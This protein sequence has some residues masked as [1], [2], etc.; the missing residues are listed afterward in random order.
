LLQ[1]SIVNKELTGNEYFKR[2]YIMVDLVLREENLINRIFL[3]RGE[4][5]MLDFDLAMLYETEA[6]R[7]KASVRRNIDRFPGDFMFEL[8]KEEYNSLRTKFSSSNRG[9]I[10]YMPYAFT[11]QGVAMLSTVLKSK[12]AIEVNI[13]IMRI[14]VQ[15]RKIANIHKELFERIENLETNFE[16]LKDLVRSLL[17]QETKPK[18]KIGFIEA[19]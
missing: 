1:S 2:I 13:A 14:F 5:V 16:S 6:K 17:I 10:R 3:I 19:E 11:E 18:R 9:G 15:L 8:T 12:K 4:K 7:L